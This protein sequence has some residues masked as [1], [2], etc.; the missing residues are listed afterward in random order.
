M[1]RE[2]AWKGYFLSEL[3]LRLDE[4]KEA[5]R[6]GN[7]G[8]ALRLLESAASRLWQV[9]NL[10]SEVKTFQKK[11]EEEA[12]QALID[13]TRAIDEGKLHSGIRKLRE[14]EA[15]YRGSASAVQ[16][17]VL[18]AKFEKTPRFAREEEAQKLLAKAEELLKQKEG[19]RARDLVRKILKDFA[20]T[21]AAEGA[22][23]L[24]PRLG[25]PRK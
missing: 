2:T 11:L 15:S 14:V 13:A 24:E 19:G 8:E 23:A 12:T 20:D 6:G 4:A 7:P 1:L 10:A 16:A 3:R 25:P 18:I 5:A 21:E 17:S 22:K 9:E